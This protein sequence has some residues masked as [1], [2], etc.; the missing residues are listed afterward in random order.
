LP[1]HALGLKWAATSHN[2]CNK[3]DYC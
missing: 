1:K 2:P 3:H